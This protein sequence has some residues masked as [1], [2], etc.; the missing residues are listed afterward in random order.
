MSTIKQN[1]LSPLEF[2]FIIKR[3]PHVSYFAQQVSV[4]GVSM[5]VDTQPTPFRNIYRHG[6]TLEFNDLSITIRIDE[7]MQNYLEIVNWMRGLTKPTE[8]SEWANLD[9]SDDGLYSDATLTIMSN[10]KNPNIEITF[11]DIF[12]IDI[13]DIEFSATESDLEYATVSITFK[14]NDYVINVI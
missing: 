7:N 6:D 12:P 9:A 10:A 3:L 4:P 11:Y 5:D 2:R 14:V 1:F 13:G 8:F